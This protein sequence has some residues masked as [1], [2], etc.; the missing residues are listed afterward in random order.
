MYYYKFWDNVFFADK[1]VELFPAEEKE[2]IEVELNKILENKC[3]NSAAGAK[4]DKSMAHPLKD[5]EI[6]KDE[7]KW[8]TK[9]CLLATKKKNTCLIYH[10]SLSSIFKY[11]YKLLNSL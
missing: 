6:S 7:Q 11:E 3:K 1:T 4:T 9:Y 10:S 5:E 8:R 2:D